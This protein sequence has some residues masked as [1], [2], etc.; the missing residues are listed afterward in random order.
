MKFIIYTEDK[1]DSLSIRKANRDAHLAF[2]RSDDA[3][4]KLLTAGPW[5]DDE[6]V[7]RG[8]ILIVE[9]EDKTTVESWLA[10]DP[11]RAAGLTGKTMIK[12]F[13]WAIGAPE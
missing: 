8:S 4:V 7:M 9:A 6:E 1:P 13:I 5:L 10:E 2:L 11:Y 12:A 3:P